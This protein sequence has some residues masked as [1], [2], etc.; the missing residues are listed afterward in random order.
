MPATELE[1]KKSVIHDGARAGF[2]AFLDR[3]ESGSSDAQAVVALMHLIGWVDNE[4]Q[5][6]NAEY[7]AAKSAEAGNAYGRWV[8]AWTRLEKSD[9]QEGLDSL[10]KSAEQGFAPAISYLADFSLNGVIVPMDRNMAIELAATGANL[11]HEYGRVLTAELD[12]RGYSGFLR[13]IYSTLFFPLVNKVRHVSYRI[14]LKT[15][16]VNR[17]SYARAFVVENEIRRKL[18]G[19][20]VD[21]KYENQLYEFMPTTR[22]KSR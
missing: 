3:A 12:K 2:F 14:R 9:Y 4:I 5:L 20:M 10:I 16:D 7:W 13:M 21:S 11:G 1:A 17:L 19:E 8:L 18:K 15:Y 6:D 22:R